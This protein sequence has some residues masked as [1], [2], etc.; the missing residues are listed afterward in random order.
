MKNILM[1]YIRFNERSL[2]SIHDPVNLV[3]IL[4]INL[5]NFKNF[6]EL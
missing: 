6:K 1:K 5:N 2:F 4:N 3:I